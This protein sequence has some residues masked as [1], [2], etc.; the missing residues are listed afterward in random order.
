MA[1]YPGNAVR[2]INA[3]K[4][5]GLKPQWT[6][7]L[8]RR[9]LDS[10]GKIYGSM[11]GNDLGAGSWSYTSDYPSVK[12]G[13]IDY[14][15]AKPNGRHSANNENVRRYIDFAS[16]NGFDALLVEG[17]N[18][19]WEDWA[20]CFQRLRFRLSNSLSWFWYW[21]IEW[22]CPFERNSFDDAP[23]KFIV[24]AK[25]RKTYGRRIRIDG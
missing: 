5:I 23:W 8:R 7:C 11:V 22:L 21:S 4:Q 9:F 10:P 17:W 14:A 16:A 15:K 12:L 19:G 18:I 25:L 24:S 20:D 1:Y 13:K 6:L 2:G 3:G